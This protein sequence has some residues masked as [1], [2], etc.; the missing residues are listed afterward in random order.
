MKILPPI[1]FIFSLLMLIGCQSN[2]LTVYKIDIQQGN[3]LEADTVA[4]IN[5]GMSKEQVQFLLG[6]PILRDS[7]HPDRWDYIYHFTPGYGKQER[8][9]L[10]LYF[11]RDEV[12]DIVKQNIVSNDPATEEN[13]AQSQEKIDTAES[14]DEET[15]L[16]EEEKQALEEQAENLE[17]T[18]DS[19]NDPTDLP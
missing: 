8:R 7:F 3:A 12:V 4:K 10:I 16:T 6:S 14:S 2:L 1:I 15:N 11:D 19:L 13:E 17:D 18:I 9:Q 5:T